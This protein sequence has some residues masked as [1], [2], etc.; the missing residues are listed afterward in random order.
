MGYG[1]IALG[2]LVPLKTHEILEVLQAISEVRNPEVGLHLFGITR[3]ESVLEFERY[4][5]TSFDSTSPFRQAFKDERDNYY[6]PTET[7]IALRVPQV[8]G[9]AKLQARI[10]SGQ[11]EQGLALGLERDVLEALVA[12]DRDEVGIE[13]AVSA[14]RAYEILHDGTKDRSPEYR[15]T[16]EARPWKQCPCS[17]CRDVGIQVVLFRGTERNKRRGFHNLHVFS[18]RLEHA[19]AGGSAATNPQPVAA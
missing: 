1:R 8:E 7:F 17:V 13:E 3:C 6:T 9:N 18:G 4:G 15:R 11:V 5:A 12:F 19:L 10:R 2:G 14:L 16:L